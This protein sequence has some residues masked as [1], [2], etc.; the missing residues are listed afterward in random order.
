VKAPL[1]GGAYQARSIIADAQ[2]CLNLFPEV[3]NKDAPFETTHYPT[4]GLTLLTTLA[5]LGPV[6][7]VYTASNGDLFACA[8]ASVY[9]I[10]SSWGAIALG[11]I[12]YGDTPVSFSDNNVYCVLV[13][14]GVPPADCGWTI[15][16]STH[17]FAVWSDP[18]FLGGGRVVI[19]DTFFVLNQPG[20]Q[21]F[22]HSESN[23]ITFNGL[24]IAAKT[25]YQDLLST[26]IANRQ[27]LWLFGTQ[28]ATELWYNAGGSPMAFQ[29]VPSITVEHGCLAKYSAQCIGQGVFWLGVDEQ[30]SAMVWRGEGYA[31]KRVSTFAIEQ[32][33]QKYADLEN[34]QS[35][36]YQIGGHFFYVLIFPTADK[37]WVF[38]ETV[39]LWHEW[40]WIDD[41]GEEHRP[42]ANC[43]TVAYGKHIVGDWEDGS[44]YELSPDVYT[45]AGDPIIRVRSWPHLLFGIDAQGQPIPSDGKLLIHDQFIADIQCGTTTDADNEPFCSLRWSDTR[46][47]SWGNAV[48]QSLGNTGEYLVQPQWRQLGMARD[49]IYELSW[50]VAVATGL[51]GAYVNSRLMGK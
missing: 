9:Y 19:D 17:A 25:D 18:N 30:G 49:R 10:N 39:G 43:H 20:T 22:Y 48:Q 34:T 38:D 26:I 24:A 23:L 12:T 13:D 51:N 28:R 27:N 3:N 36:T 40:C 44:I 50:S 4:P 47:A 37:C 14:G 45:D 21:F 32:A 8:G 33:I 41:N 15:N 35:F 1:I 29:Q 11:T 7:G 2:R 5:S 16:L 42:R 31:A 6:R 46:G